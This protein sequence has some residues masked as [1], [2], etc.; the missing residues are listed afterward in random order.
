[1]RNYDHVQHPATFTDGHRM[2]EKHRPILAHMAAAFSD[3][4]R[5][6]L[7]STEAIKSELATPRTQHGFEVAPSNPS[8]QLSQVKWALPLNWQQTELTL[9]KLG[10]HI[11]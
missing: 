9:I 7:H 11:A 4:T 6:P 8:K 3:E 10:F 1:M 2:P 5:I